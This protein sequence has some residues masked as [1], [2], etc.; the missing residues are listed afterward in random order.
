LVA[1]VLV[2][3]FGAF[4]VFQTAQPHPGV[5][6]DSGEYLAVSE[7]LTEGHGFTMP[8]VNFDEPWRI[9]GPEERVAMVQFPPL[10][11][12]TLAGVQE[13]VGLS[14]LDAA[15]VIGTGAFLL[16]I[17]LV[18]RVVYRWT[19]RTSAAL[20]AG[21]LSIAPDLQ[22]AHAM[23]WSESL[24]LLGLGAAL[25]ATAT[26]LETQRTSALIVAGFAAS[27]AS[28]ARLAGVAVIAGVAV[29]LSIDS[30]APLRRR[31]RTAALFA[32]LSSIPL[33]A[34]LVRNS[35]VYGAPS[36]KTIGLHPP[37][38]DA[39]LQMARTI[40]NWLV[41]G[42]IAAIVCGVLVLVVLVTIGRAPIARALRGQ[43]G[44][45][46]LTCAGLGVAYLAFVLLSRTFLDQNIPLDARILA[47]I[48][49]LAIVWICAT[50]TPARDSVPRVATSV[51]V[52][53]LGVFT[54]G[55]SLWTATEFSGFD[56]TSYTND[57]WRASPTL[58]HVGSV[59]EDTMVISNGVDAIWLWHDRPTQLIP[60]RENLYSGSLNEKYPDQVQ[61]LVAATECREAIV[62]FFNKPTR[63][64]KRVIE[65]RLVI[66]L[67]L[68]EVERLDDGIVYSVEEP[69]GACL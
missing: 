17:L 45:L 54:L 11:P 69:R 51:A 18:M 65:E 43:S 42:R 68:D 27:L 13:A 41:P 61:Q 28:L 59:P 40:G 53:L 66:E 20:L 50:F 57:R 10:Y 5:S 36:E 49:I 64:P 46:P 52:V 39:F 19:G 23:A 33:V 44:S 38:A 25:Y 7:G 55:R 67:G 1:S 22:I 34:W 15:R 56:V 14:S 8:Y 37:G 24:M 63:K 58:D 62:V 16:T 32:L 4:L 26:Y 31:I 47:P 29:V 60:S 9:V 3:A 48:Q 2:A 12:A 30:T 6:V 35:L 21:A